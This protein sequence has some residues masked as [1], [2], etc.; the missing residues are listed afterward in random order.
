MFIVVKWALLNSR[1]GCPVLDW[2]NM[3]PDLLVYISMGIILISVA[4]YGV[5]ENLHADRNCKK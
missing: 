4:V 2:Y 5:A 3:T 1:G